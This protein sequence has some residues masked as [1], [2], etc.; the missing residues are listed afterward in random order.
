MAYRVQIRIHGVWS[1]QDPEF[2]KAGIWILFQFEH[3][4]TKFLQ[5]YT[6]LCIDHIIRFRLRSVLSRVRIRPVR[7]RIRAAL[8]ANIR[9]LPDM[10][11]TSQLHLFILRLLCPIIYLYLCY[12]SIIT[13][14]IAYSVSI[15]DILDSYYIRCFIPIHIQCF[16]PILYD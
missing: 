13:Y 4:D 2:K 5:K 7:I 3:R 6:S 12:M 10:Q 1:D 11:G 15:I 8:L 16:I 14:Q 9:L